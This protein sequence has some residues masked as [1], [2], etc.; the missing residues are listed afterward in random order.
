MT[1]IG[2]TE[3]G[4]TTLVK[5]ILPTRSHVLMVATK[6]EDS[7]I[8]EMEV[9]GYRVSH[10][11]DIRVRDGRIIDDRFIFWPVM[12]RSRAGRD[13]WRTPRMDEFEDHQRA[14]VRRALGYVWRTRRWCVYV[15]EVAWV[16]GRQHGLGIQREMTQLWFQGRTMGITVVVAT[17]RPSDIPRAAYS[18]A[19]HLF[20]FQ[21]GD[22]TDLEN[23]ADIGGGIDRKPLEQAIESLREHEFLY[24][25]RGSPPLLVRSKVEL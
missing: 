13:G 12:I 19:K 8:Q 23:L 15:D 16:A 3:S 17:Q 4:K 21:T 14:Q 1:V 18:Q 22:R 25:R 2:P 11:L 7:L 20:W 10:D 24:F 9:D 6:P 5:E